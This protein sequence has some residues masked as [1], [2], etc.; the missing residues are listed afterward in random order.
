[1]DNTFTIDVHL[2]TIRFAIKKHKM[3]QDDVGG[4]SGDFSMEFSFYDFD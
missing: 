3:V 4:A 2:S 1:L